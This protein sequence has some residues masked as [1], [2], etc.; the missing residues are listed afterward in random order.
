[1]PALT[2]AADLRRWHDAQAPGGPGGAADAWLDAAAALRHAA[3]DVD[4]VAALS[5]SAAFQTRGRGPAVSG[6]A[7][8]PLVGGGVRAD[9]AVVVGAQ[10]VEEAG[11]EAVA[12]LAGQAVRAAWD[13]LGDESPFELR[14]HVVDLD[15]GGRL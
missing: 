4:G 9:V 2:T 13:R 7:L 3:L 5:G 8:A 11:V 12:R 14:V 15:V 1:M 10:A 6:V